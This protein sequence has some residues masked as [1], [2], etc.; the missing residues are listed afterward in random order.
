MKPSSGPA[1]DS[2]LTA[3]GTSEA[4]RREAFCALYE[5][6]AGELQSYLLRMTRSVHAAEDLTQEAF[7]KAYQSLDG[8]TGKSSF[9]TWIY[10]IA[11]N[12]YRDQ[13]KRA[14]KMVSGEAVLK[15]TQA[16]TKTPVALAEREEEGER[17]RAAVA[18][19]PAEWREAV[20]LVRIEEMSYREAAGALGI[21][22]DALRMRV[23]RAHLALVK[24]LA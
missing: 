3:A 16:T 23:H 4:E 10:S 9:R 24:A 22:L 1:P 21:T 13:I 6:H 18:A 19:L 20:L 11:I 12:L 14:G 2:A 7:L 8:F 15:N 17:V 5:R